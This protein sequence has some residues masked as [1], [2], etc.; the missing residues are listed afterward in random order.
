MT[1]EDR[2]CSLER[3]GILDTAPEP[4]FDSLV[5]VARALCETPVALI[6]LVHRDRQWFKARLGF[7]PHETPINQSVCVHALSVDDLLVI[8]DLTLDP[9]TRH[10]TLVTEA[11]HIRFYAGAPLIASDGAVLGSLCVIDTV[12]R[13]GLTEA[14]A[15]GL[16]ALAGQVII[17]IEAREHSRKVVE[18]SERRGSAADRAKMRAEA[19]VELG[20]RLREAG[21]VED[22]V[23][24]GSALM[25]RVLAPSRAGF[26]IVD[27]ERET[28]VMQP[29]WR[30]AGVDSVAGTHKFRD[31]GSYLDDLVRGDTVVIADV[32]TDPRT[33]D[34]AEALQSLRIRVMINVPIFQMGRFSLVSFAHYDQLRVLDADDVFFIRSMGDRIQAALGQIRAMDDRR[35]MMMELGHRLKN[36][37]AMSSAIAR[38]TFGGAEPERLAKF[39][40]RLGAMASAYALLAEERWTETD[41][42]A[43]IAAGPWL[44]NDLRIVYDGPHVGLS[45]A[46]APTVSMLLHELAT[47]AIKH[48]ALSSPE[49]EVRV[50]WRVDEGDLVLDWEERGGPAVVEPSERGFGSRLIRAGLDGSGRSEVVYDVAGLRGR[51]RAGIEALTAR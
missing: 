29:E 8:P 13:A 40:H 15:V 30:A 32:E 35:V 21:S 10:N 25:A 7:E 49:G 44:T 5:T 12:P 28:V 27:A 38:Q 51:F 14:Q 24:V 41:L 43:L 18:E 42:H 11:P 4:E 1:E 36:T 23:R 50:S 45:A 2:I 20:D 3:T 39:N 48:G 19:M 22:M 16:R 37:F 31:Y 33:R 17:Q 26:G 9:R 47:N 6:S 34:N 46:A